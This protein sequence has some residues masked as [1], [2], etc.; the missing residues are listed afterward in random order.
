MYKSFPP[1]HPPCNFSRTYKI[2]CPIFNFEL[3]ISL[4]HNELRHSPQAVN[5]LLTSL[6]VCG[7]LA[8]TRGHTKDMGRPQRGWSTVHQQA[9]KMKMDGLQAKEIAEKIGVPVTKIYDM[10]RTK[11]FIEHED[12][13][14]TN[15]VE[16]ARARLEGKLLQATD[17]IVNIMMSGKP[18]DRIRFDAAKEVLYQCGMKPVEVIET[19]GRDYSPEEIQSSLTVIREVQA[20]EEK[21]ST[22]GSGFLLKR[23]AEPS[24]SAPVNATRSEEEKALLAEA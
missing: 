3:C 10:V 24:L 13:A 1:T 19:R 6:Q 2:T 11:K 18:E 20:I 8:V 16:K 4:C 23:D 5:I 15:A 17:K 22:Q 7:I 14:I 9:F 21:L 12:K